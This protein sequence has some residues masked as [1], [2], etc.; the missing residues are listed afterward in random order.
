MIRPRSFN[1]ILNDMTKIVMESLSIQ[2]ASSED[3]DRL[4][5]DYGV[6]RKPAFVSCQH[7]WATYNSG[8]TMYEY[9]K[10]CGEKKT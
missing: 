3:L 10:H 1:E 7:E 2:T 9:C 6:I 5:N 8:F 4:A